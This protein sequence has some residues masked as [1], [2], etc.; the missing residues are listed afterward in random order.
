MGALRSLG[1]GLMIGASLLA[2]RWA[3]SRSGWPMSRTTPRWASRA[4]SWA[5]PA[6]VASA[7]EALGLDEDFPMTVDAV[8]ARLIARFG[9]APAGLL[10]LIAALLPGR[11]RAAAKT[12][13]A[14]RDERP[15]ATRA[16]CARRASRPGRSP[17]AAAPRT[18][19]SIAF[20]SGLLEEAAAYFIE[21]EEF[22][23]RG[24][25]PPR[26]EP[27][28]R[29][30]R[31]LPPGRASSTPPAASSPAGRAQARRRGATSK[32]GHK[33]VAAE[34]FEKA[35]DFRRAG[36]C[37]AQ[38]DFA[39][40]AAKAYVK[41]N[42]WKK[43]AECLDQVIIEESTAPAASDPARQAETR[44]LVRMAGKLYGRAGQHAKA[45]ASVRAGRAVD[46][47][48]RSSRS[49]TES[50]SRRRRSSRRAATR[51][52]RRRR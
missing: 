18:P 4:A 9:L 37:Y 2:L 27:L 6:T 29:V 8:P 19:P 32:A 47:G 50:T 14:P 42:D 15:K 51:S 22:V 26:P 36:D 46:S 21:A 5:R 39:R 49:R 3:A 43:A 11:R 10:L 16:R 34:M 35:G 1:R 38:T 13:S 45:Q 24:R 28:R 7:V 12:T 41:C 31:A 23:A 20:A 17:S 33:S 48:R 25:D 44:K 40:H 30:R 52:A